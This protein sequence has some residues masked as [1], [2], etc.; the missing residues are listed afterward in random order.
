MML[1]PSAWPLPLA[2]PQRLASSPQQPELV[3]PPQQPELAW[4]PQQP[5]LVWPPQR[6]VPPEPASQRGQAPL[7]RA[8][9]PPPGPQRL[10]PGRWAWLRSRVPSPPE[11]AW[12][13]ALLWSRRAWPRRRAPRQAARRAWPLPA[14]PLS[15]SLSPPE[16]AW[17]LARAALR[18]PVW[19]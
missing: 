13:Q 3:W 9:L 4:P 10:A 8:W 11:L 16:L 19:R 5:E 6:V 2:V 15:P 18:P 12:R 7:L 17:P 1:A 14:L